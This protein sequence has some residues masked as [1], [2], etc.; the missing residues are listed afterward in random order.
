MG[1]SHPVTPVIQPPIHYDSPVVVTGG[2]GLLG[3]E[4]VRQ[5]AE[6]GCR[7]V[8]VVDLQ[9]PPGAD[10]GVV[11]PHFMDIRHGDLMPAFAGS[12]TVLHL[13]ACQSHSPLAPTTCRLPSFAINVEGTR[14]ALGAA[15]WT[16]V[17]AFVH[18]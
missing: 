10:R 8:R 12:R 4:V 2:A 11:R 5:L 16:A 3:R 18:V 15:R 9:A 7:D 6:G 14:R 13:A 1:E 17:G